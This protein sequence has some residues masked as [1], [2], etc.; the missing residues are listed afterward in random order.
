VVLAVLLPVL[1]FA[2]LTARTEP[3]APVELP[4]WVEPAATE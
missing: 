4:E 3:L 1:F 2:S